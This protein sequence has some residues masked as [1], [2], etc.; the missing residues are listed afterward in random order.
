M[1]GYEKKAK[2][3][4]VLQISASSWKGK[5]ARIGPYDVLIAACDS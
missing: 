2:K 5:G 3:L 1:G 4:R